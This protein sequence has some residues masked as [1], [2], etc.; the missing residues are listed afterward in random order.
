MSR[1]TLDVYLGIIHTNMDPIV[2]SKVESVVGRY[3][4]V[5]IN[6]QPLSTLLDKF[7]SLFA[8]LF[9]YLDNK[10]HVDVLD[11]T[12]SIDLLDIFTST[13]KWWLLT[14]KDPYI[15]IRPSS[16]DPRNFLSSLNSV[17]IGSLTLSRISGS[18]D[19]LSRFLDDQDILESNDYSELTDAISSSWVLLSAFICKN[20][21]RNVTNEEDFERAYDI[22]R[23][24]LF[25]T[26][27]EDFRSLTAIRQ[28]CT[29]SII[30]CL[31]DVILSSEFEHQLN[32]STA[33]HLELNN[34]EML[35][36]TLP[37]NPRITRNV[38]TDAIRFLVR[39]VAAKEGIE[40][41]DGTYYEMLTAKAIDLLNSIGISPSS[42]AN[43]QR[44]LEIFKMLKFL[45]EVDERISLLSR[46]IESLI[47]TS[48]GNKEF[49]LQHPRLVSQIVS[50]TLLVSAL[51]KE[52]DSSLGYYD[53]KRGLILVNQI[54]SNV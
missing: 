35:S 23:V 26:P 37:S 6:G 4:K 34:S 11:L 38:L 52:S 33:A 30:P 48:V 50:L 49:L 19:R 9:A 15:T 42:L 8:K 22:I 18:L 24:L 36:K 13:T 28:I 54:I 51:T 44:V 5:M 10:S 3:T 39:I 32:S 14:R 20:Q 12:T 17:Q 25:Y 47:I 43:E 45:P 27:R 41:V 53:I 21:G 16:H 31:A 40:H 46:R 29:S 1:K 7:I 2:K